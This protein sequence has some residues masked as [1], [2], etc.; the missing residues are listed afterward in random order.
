MAVAI[1]PELGVIEPL[2]AEPATQPSHFL[3]ATA[4]VADELARVEPVL[5]DDRF[6]AEHRVDP[7]QAAE[8]VQIRPERCRHDDH[9][10]AL[11]LVPCQPS[12]SVGSEPP[13]VDDRG[14]L[15]SETFD[16][17]DLAAR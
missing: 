15:S 6:G 14:E 16:V 13:A 10:V 1:R 3:R 7:E 2:L 8:R 5:T 11:F 12:R 17:L 4:V 9:T